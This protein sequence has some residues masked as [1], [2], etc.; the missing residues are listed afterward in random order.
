MWVSVEEG[1]REGEGGG[2]DTELKKPTRQ[3]GEKSPHCWRCAKGG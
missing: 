2:A 3:C 1:G